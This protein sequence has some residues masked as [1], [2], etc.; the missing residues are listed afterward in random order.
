MTP[1]PTA[2]RFLLFLTVAAAILAAVIVYPLWGAV[3]L[4][5]VLAAT[6]RPWMERLS[7][8]L[9]G[10][11]RVASAILVVVALLAIVL[12]VASLGTVVVGQVLDG[13][14]SVRETFERGGLWGLVRRL[15]GPIEDAVRK[16]LQAVPNPQRQIQSLA[17]TQGGEAAKAVGGAIA[18]TGNVLFQTV[19]ML[20][21]LFFFLVDGQ[22]LVAW[23]GEALPLERRQY[24]ALVEDFRRTSVAVLVS[25]LGTAGVQT[26]LA[27]IGYF[28]AR[29]PSPLFL[30]VVTFVV[31]LI[32]A[33]GGTV[34]VVLVAIER[35]ASGHAFAGVFLLVWGLGFISIADN[36]ARPYLLKG[37]MELHGGVVLF[38]L[39]GGLAV[40]GGLG[41]LV[42]PLITTFLV[43]VVRLYRR[44]YGSPAEAEEEA[45]ELREA[46]ELE[47]SPPGDDRHPPLS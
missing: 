4:A 26:V 40:F 22:R 1:R 35:L 39:L 44:D 18:A 3:F 47:E 5:A 46:G 20:I 12:P 10:R 25:T 19:M 27:T 33:L 45:A 42:G 37:G 41:V 21:A 32:P 24:R 16:L 34:V 36:I 15:P 9:G 17:G 31:A 2:Q 14:A 8:A 43:A 13:I 30:A 29:A 11:R 38:A 7:R 28:I 6:F 23:I